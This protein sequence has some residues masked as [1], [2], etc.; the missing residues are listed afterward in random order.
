VQRYLADVDPD[1]E[2]VGVERTVTVRTG[3][4]SLW[5]RVDRIDDRGGTGLAVVD[6]KTGRTPPTADDV[7]SSL[8]LA[9]YAAAV[10]RT[11]RRTCRRVELHHLPTG[12]VVGWD[13]TTGSLDRQL[14]RADSLA[15]ELATVEEQRGLVT[16]RAEADDLFPAR[17]G[18]RCGWC[19]F[20]SACGPGQ[21]VPRRLPWAGVED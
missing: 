19:D 10:A 14:R 21:A 5:G 17:V 2:P 18:S 12:S 4:A 8:T 7:G 16:S 11:L 15:T 3:R 6:Y 9:V 1:D 20:R 13:H